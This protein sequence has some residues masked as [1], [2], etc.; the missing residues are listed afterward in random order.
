V[1]QWNIRKKIDRLQIQNVCGRCE[2]INSFARAAFIAYDGQSNLF[3]YVWIIIART[4]P[5]LP[6][7]TRS[8][9]GHGVII[10][11]RR[12]VV[13][14]RRR[15]ST[16]QPPPPSRTRL[17]M[18]TSLSVA[19]SLS[20]HR[21][22]RGF[23]T[24]CATWRYWRSLAPSSRTKRLFWSTVR[25][26]RTVPTVWR[27]ARRT[28]AASA[29][30]R[31]AARSRPSRCCSR[32]SRSCCSSCPT[33]TTDT[34]RTRTH[35]NGTPRCASLTL[36][37][38]TTR[39]PR[40][41]TTTRSRPAWTSPTRSR[42]ARSSPTPRVSFTTS[43]WT[44]PASSTCR[45]NGVSSC[46][47]PDGRSRRPSR[48][49]ISCSKCPPATIRRTWGAPWPGCA[50]SSRPSTTCPATACTYPKTV[51]AIPRTCCH[52]SSTT[53]KRRREKY[54]RRVVVVTNPFVSLYRYLC[55]TYCYT[56][57]M[58]RQ[59]SHLNRPIIE[60]STKDKFKQLF[61]IVTLV[62]T[63]D[64]RRRL[65]LLGTVQTSCWSGFKKLRILLCNKNSQHCVCVIIIPCAP[66]IRFTLKIVFSTI[67]IWKIIQILCYIIYICIIFVFLQ[68][69]NNKS[70]RIYNCRWVVSTWDVKHTSYLKKQQK[71]QQITH[72]E[73]IKNIV[74]V[75]TVCTN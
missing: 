51:P 46:R 50:S 44:S 26:C 72:F 43:A 75:L 20:A 32:P 25:R 30:A 68:Y 9:R 73:F 37:P 71:D 69:P 3:L 62:G 66:I 10:F 29:V 48:S 67:N 23:C 56:T 14:F 40:P 59:I 5:R 63:S 8:R 15:R 60:P 18:F 35:K 34:S 36:R 11:A 7:S 21:F 12:F 39:S 17:S 49:T 16:N 42:P 55:P 58:F 6:R 70:D 27:T 13:A 2:R 54:T 31:R 65:F 53:C 61:S 28:S 64:I 1:L 57:T 45:P 33:R 47:C 38:K 19:Q 22:V 4:A 41:R 52:P 24:T 74:Y